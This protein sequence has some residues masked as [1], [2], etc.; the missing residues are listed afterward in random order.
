MDFKFY[1]SDDP[2]S[3]VMLTSRQEILHKLLKEKVTPLFIWIY[4]LKGNHHL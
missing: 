2:D 1:H 3:L 4:K